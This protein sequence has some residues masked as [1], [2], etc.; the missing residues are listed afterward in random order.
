MILRMK[1]RD[2]TEELEVLALS[3][4]AM[5]VAHSPLPTS[6]GGVSFPLRVVISTNHVLVSSADDITSL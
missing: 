3:I 5:R 6:P 4:F 1:R 2:M